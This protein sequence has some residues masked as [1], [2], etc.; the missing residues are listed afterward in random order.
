MDPNDYFEIAN[1]LINSMQK[2][3]SKEIF[4]RT[5]IN[6]LYYGIFHL[7]QLELGIIIPDSH[8]KKSHAYV[9]KQIED[10]KIRSDYSDLEAYRV[11]VDY[12]IKNKINFNHYNDALKIQQ[13]ILNSIKEPEFLPFEKEDEDF[14]FKIK[15]QK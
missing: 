13:R 12:S 2:K 11:D 1:F 3:I 5:A 4:Y 14:Y 8:I 10:T 15:N 7:V 9:K 6:R